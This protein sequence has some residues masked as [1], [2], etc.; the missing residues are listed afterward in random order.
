MF[1]SVVPRSSKSLVLL[2]MFAA[3]GSDCVGNELQIGMAS[4]DITP[5]TGMTHDPLQAKT[6]VL[7]QGDCTAALVVC[8]L[9]AVSGRQSSAIRSLASERTGIPSSHM[10]IAATHTHDGGTHPDLIERVATAICDAQ[11]SLRPATL[12]AGATEQHGIAFNRRFLM[13]DGTVRFNPGYREGVGSFDGGHPFLNPEIVRPVGPIDPELG[14]LWMVDDA[15]G[16][17]M[18]C[19]AN[20]ALHVCTANT[21]GYS[22][23]FP[24]VMET[25]L[26]EKFGDEFIG[27]F[28]AGTCGDVNHFDVSKPHPVPGH[29]GITRTIGEALAASVNKVLPG[30]KSAQGSLAVQQAIIQAPLQDYSEMDLTW[31]RDAKAN[32]FSDFGGTGYNQPGFLAGVRARKILKLEEYRRQGPTM[33]LEVQA[34]RLGDDVAVVALPGELFVELG[35]SIKAASPFTTTIVIELANSDDCYYVPTRKAFIEAGYEVVYS[36]LAPGGGDMLVDKAVELLNDLKASA[37]E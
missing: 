24:G 8:D 34:F 25:E 1:D 35:L 31:A 19:L 11:K 17:P 33:A 29:E 27:V 12:Q 10:A 37:S 14:V 6:I 3:F 5:E 7:S 16:K 20:Y 36:M 18:G 32:G 21:A 2:T 22:A 28:A 4:V 30:L 9:I 23:D 26:Q 15:T 13:K